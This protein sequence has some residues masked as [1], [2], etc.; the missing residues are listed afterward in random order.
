MKK[1]IAAFLL[2][3]AVA[4]GA[5]IVGIVPVDV[6]V[7][8]PT[9]ESYVSGLAR[10]QLRLEG[11][12]RLRL[13][14]VLSL[15]AEQVAVLSPDS[16]N[17]PIVIVDEFAASIGL[18]D[19]LRGRIHLRHVAAKT[20]RVDYCAELTAATNNASN[21]QLPS[22]AIGELTV[23]KTILTCQKTRELPAIDVD[24]LR[25]GAQIDR[26]LELTARI[27]YANFEIDVNGSTA[28]LNDILQRPALIPLQVRGDTA[29]A[30]LQLDGEV[31]TPFDQPSLAATIDLQIDDL[32]TFAELA[33][34]YINK[35][36]AGELTGTLTADAA[37]IGIDG[38]TGKIGDTG[39]ELTSTV[40]QRTPRPH[41]DLALRIEQFDIEA[42]AAMSGESATDDDS[43]DLQ[44]VFDA[45][46][47]IDADIFVEALEVNIAR[48]LAR[49]LR[50]DASLEDGRFEIRNA[51]FNSAVASARLSG[52][53]DTQAAC[54]SLLANVRLDDI[55]SAAIAQWATTAPLATGTA[56]QTELRITS[57]GNTLRA[58]LESARAQV[59]ASDVVMTP[60]GWESAITIDRLDLSGGWRTPARADLAGRWRGTDIAMTGRTGAV[61]A[62]TEQA[63]VPLDINI[64]SD[65]ATLAFAGSGRTDGDRL[66]LS[67]DVKID[68]T[69]LGSTYAWSGVDPAANAAMAIAAAIDFRDEALTIEDLL[70]TVGES[71]LTGRLALHGDPAGPIA[72]VQLHARYLDIDGLASLLPASEAT[73]SGDTS[74]N[75]SRFDIRETNLP[76]A[77]LD[78]SADSIVFDQFNFT[79]FTLNGRMR[80]RLIADAQL[81]VQIEETNLTGTLDLDFRGK[82]PI[83]NL[84]VGAANVDL[85]RLL[86]DLEVVDDLQANTKQV[87]L[88]YASRGATVR[89]FLANGRLRANLVNFHWE[90]DDEDGRRV[91]DLILD[92]L[93][94]DVFPDAP[95][96]WRSAGL[97]NDVPVKV[98]IETPTLADTFNTDLPL[99]VHV[100]FLSADDVALLDAQVN[101]GRS[102][103]ITATLNLSG[104]RVDPTRVELSE[105]TPPLAAYE[106]K[107]TVHAGEERIDVSDLNIRIGAGRIG[108]EVLIDSIDD[109]HRI[110]L[111]V[112]ASHLQ[113]DDFVAAADGWRQ[114]DAGTEPEDAVAD[115]TED[116]GLL[117]MLFETVTA[118]TEDYDIDVKLAIDEL[119]GGTNYLGAAEFRF[120]ADED[121]LRIS[122]LQISLP[123]GDVNIEYSLRDVSGRADMELQLHIDRLEYTGLPR[124][125]NPEL[126]ASGLVYLDVSLGATA[127]DRAGLSGAIEGTA[128][129]VLLPGDIDASVL[130]LWVANVVFA[131]LPAPADTRTKKLNCMVV[132]FDVADGVMQSKTV[133][134]DSTDV[135][136]RGKGTIDLV[137]RQIDMLVGPQAKREKFLSMSTPVKITG[138]WSDFQIGVV[139]GGL[140]ATAFRWYMNLI[141]VP[142]KWLTG[143]R[144]PADGY[145]TCFNEMGWNLTPEI[146]TAIRDALE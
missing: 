79:D 76:R 62:I 37:T 118:L 110:T 69:R 20:I 67:G 85:G 22:V 53:L 106:I 98:W 115:P 14:A 56:R 108:G 42:F 43:G 143:E 41:V 39:F 136:V 91:A 144:F 125:L 45:M 131:I 101:R 89:A 134:L 25:V 95:T 109:R 140:M 15:R 27:R 102:P 23:G 11:R 7:F 63:E 116:D 77:D 96:V 4:A 68:V 40:Q 82:E 90:H 113:T 129:L 103:G 18:V 142:F 32:Q 54:P 87:T 26:P 31:S 13:G 50:V 2:V 145:Q 122:P 135:I 38:A 84:N 29:D 105:L 17:Q 36:M 35:P 74:N 112:A 61:G 51:T 119:Y 44:P 58:N 78:L 46:Q 64:T 52:S 83:L 117:P 139:P 93:S 65:G 137:N 70:A 141:Y 92:E 130:D 86:A 126:E 60:A 123:G 121:E 19:V 88:N 72:A 107:A 16:G 132:R 99:P 73:A 10:I 48:L 33:G 6:A 47:L 146:E 3:V 94:V 138:P 75:D 97:L 49:D 1:T 66:E 80:D 120:L 55:D 59:S 100:A 114:Q 12:L 28:P 57:C 81:R 104:Q 133:M 8:S 30:R 124:L 24:D 128:D 21:D 9:I 111:E 127:P 34:L 5:V 71:T